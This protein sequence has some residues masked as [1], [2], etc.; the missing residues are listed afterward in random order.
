MHLLAPVTE[1]GSPDRDIAL[2]RK[3][4]PT[5]GRCCDKIAEV[6]DGFPLLHRLV[7]CNVNLEQLESAGLLDQTLAELA[8]RRVGPTRRNLSLCRL[9]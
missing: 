7:S 3:T 6:P 8:R 4:N 2:E 5:P 9:P 1:S